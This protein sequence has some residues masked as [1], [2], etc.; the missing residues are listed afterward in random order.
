MFSSISAVKINP[1]TT[2][3]KN[4]CAIILA[5]G[6]SRRF[7]NK[8]KLLVTLDGKPLL[9]RVVLAVTES[10]VSHVI[11]VTG[12]D[13]EN[14]KVLLSGYDVEFVDNERWREGM[15]TSLACG[16][17]AVSK[18]Q[19]NGILVCLGDLPF[20]EAATVNQVI[21]AFVDNGSQWI[22]VP[23]Y[24]GK[25]GHPVLFP[26][27]YISRL[28]KMRGDQGAKSIIRESDPIVLDVG[29]KEIIRDVDRQADF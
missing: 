9:E 20:L 25:G 5:A 19:Y 7:G 28:E 11:A 17:E 21:K 15:G 12:C 10:E 26:A 13:C 23:E 4:I 2:S 27:N 22:V 3:K 14:V 6:E 29:S 16:A 18:D 8:N 24:E 1:M